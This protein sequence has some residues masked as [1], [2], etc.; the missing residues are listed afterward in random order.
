MNPKQIAQRLTI[1]ESPTGF[2]VIE[3]ATPKSGVASPVFR[4]DP[5]FVGG[6]VLQGE[7]ESL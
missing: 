6:G 7:L 3:F 5:G 1:P 2:R 4:S